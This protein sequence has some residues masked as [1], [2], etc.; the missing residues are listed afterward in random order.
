MAAAQQLA[1]LR[2]RDGLSTLVVTTRQLYDE[3]AD[4]QSTPLALRRFLAFAG[5]SWTVAP[6]YVVL[7]GEGSYDYRNL[8][9]YDDALVPS[10]LVD[11]PYGL[12]PSDSAVGDI[13][14]DGLSEAAVGRI[15]AQTPAELAAYVGKLAAHQ[16]ATGAWRDRALFVAGREDDAGNFSADSRQLAAGLPSSISVETAF[17]AELG[18]PSV[19]EKVL[20]EIAAGTLLVNYFGHAGVTQLDSQRLLA[21]ADVGSMGNAPR[22][23][24]VAALTCVVGNFALP[25]MDGLGE[26]LTM[27]QSGGASAVWA[28]TALTL[29]ADSVALDKL[30]LAE[31]YAPT[32]GGVRLGEAVWRTQRAFV[33]QG[34]SPAVASLYGLI[35]DPAALI[36]H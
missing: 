13:N 23:P 29:H 3:F 25:G 1:D 35:G 8:L 4:G 2:A 33:A 34:G 36:S 12:S 26:A 15:P 5:S 20:A 18:G 30:F 21:A 28:P 19:R 32:A 16:V 9:G 22:L 6:R 24:V 11:T 31:L 10:L 7:A 14:G 17:V 27:A